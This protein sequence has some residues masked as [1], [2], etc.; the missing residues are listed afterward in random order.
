[1]GIP[2]GADALVKEKVISS[3]VNCVQAPDVVSLD[4]LAWIYK[5]VTYYPLAKEA[6]SL[7]L[8]SDPSL[9]KITSTL[10]HEDYNSSYS[11]ILASHIIINLFYYGQI[12]NNG[13]ERGIEAM[14]S[15]GNPLAMATAIRLSFLL[16]A[17]ANLN[18]QTKEYL[19][20]ER[21]VPTMVNLSKIMVN[22]GLNFVPQYKHHPDLYQLK[23]PSATI[24]S[25]ILFG[26]FAMVWGK[27]LWSISA[28][29]S[30]SFKALVKGQDPEH[31]KV[32]R[33]RFLKN[34][35]VGRSVFI[36]LL[37]DYLSSKL[38]HYCSG[39]KIAFNS[40][41]LVPLPK[42]LENINYP[43]SSIYPMFQ[44]SIFLLGTLYLIHT[45]RFVVVPLLLAGGYYNQDM[46]RSIPVLGK[47]GSD[48]D[49]MK[50][51]IIELNSYINN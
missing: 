8:K 21:K 18:E 41:S 20:K 38:M 16:S 36:L 5:L 40:G 44:S 10:V 34:R 39:E 48:V 13:L 30:P 47:V 11:W 49:Y 35:M 15:S 31:V 6:R 50:K 51:K 4:A 25:T 29:M 1:V 3:L 7:V 12:S 42:S 17:D 46:L 24:L 27:S 32:L 26:G 45:Q 14:V 22:I 43:L 19:V 37:F 23:G 9:Q 28:S 33:N 2:V